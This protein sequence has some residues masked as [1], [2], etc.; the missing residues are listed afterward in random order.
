MELFASGIT[1]PAKIK[2][3]TGFSRDSIRKYLANAF[4]Y[5]AEKNRESVHEYLG[6]EWEKL[7][8]REDEI[9][10]LLRNSG[11]YQPEQNKKKNEKKTGE[12]KKIDQQVS[13]LFGNLD[14]ITGRR[15]EILR[16]VDP[17][18]DES[19]DTD[20]VLVLVKNREDFRNVMDAV[21]FRQAIAA[22]DDVSS[23]KTVPGE[24]STA[25]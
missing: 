21:S 18:I 4:A 2:E 6:I 15:L 23:E 8:L 13:Q 24:S 25:R 16:M 7:N 19:Q 9:L 10:R 17:G 20:L 12:T 22:P 1:R 14:K 5:F 11:G 3:V